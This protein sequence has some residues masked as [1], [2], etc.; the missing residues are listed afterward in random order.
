LV[1]QLVT[2]KPRNPSKALNYWFYETI[3]E[4]EVSA[5]ENLGTPMKQKPQK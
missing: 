4:R 1:T 3:A 2:G 5:I